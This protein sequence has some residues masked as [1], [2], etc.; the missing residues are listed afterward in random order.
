MATLACLDEETLDNVSTVKALRRY[1]HFEIVLR[2]DGSLDELGHGAMGTTYRAVDTVLQSQVALKVIGQNVADSP[3]VRSRFLREARAAA[4]LRHPNVASVFH[5]GEQQGECFYVME[6]VEGETLEE[7]VRRDGPLPVEIVLEIGFQV[8]CALT[9]AEAQGLVHRDLKPSNL[10]WVTDP[11][12]NKPG[13]PLLIKVIDFGLAKALTAEAE[14][15]GEN[16]T[17][18]VFT[19]TPAYAS[20][21]Q[22][23]R[24]DHPVDTRSDL[25]S[26]GVTL[27]YLLCGRTPFRGNTLEEIHR[28]QTRQPLPVNQLTA[29][30]IPGPVIASL[31]SLLAVDPRQRPQ[32][33]RE[34]IGAIKQ[35]QTRISPAHRRKL[36]RLPLTVSVL[37]AVSVL[38]AILLVHRQASTVA[39]GRPEAAMADR[40][41]AV[42][43][44]E[45]LSPN[46]SVAFFTSGVQDEITGELARIA[47]LKVVSPGE[48]STR[49][50]PPGKRDLTGIGQQLGVGH[51]I[52]GAVRRENDHAQITIKLTDIRNAGLNWSKTYEG[53]LS[54]IF[55]IQ[56]EVTRE[57]ANRLRVTLSPGEKAAIDDPPTTDPVA[58]DFYLRAM[59]GP[60]EF[61]GPAEIRQAMNDKL[62][63]LD[64]AVTRDPNFVAAYCAMANIHDQLYA[65]R[66]FGDEAD[67]AVDHHTLAEVALQKAQRLQRDASDVHLAQAMHFYLVGHDQEQARIELDLA[68][69]LLPNNAELEQV[70]GLIARDQGRWDD[71]VRNLQKSVAL[72]PR[73][74]ACVVSLA[75]VYRAMRRY[76]DADRASARLIALEPEEVSLYDRLFRAL[77]PLEE[78]ADLGPLREALGAVA[79]ANEE[80][81]NYQNFFRLTLALY[82]HDAEAL[83]R[84]LAGVAHP[85]ITHRGIVYPKTW[86]EGLA[87]RLRGDG[88]AAKT[89]FA[90][91]RIN[92]ERTTLADAADAKMLSLLAVVDAGLGRKEDA[93][94]EGQRAYAMM[95]VDK[96]ASDAPVVACNLAVVF[97]WSNEP[98]RA[99]DLLETWA[100]RSAGMQMVYQVTY[101]D[102][103]LNPQWDPIRNY[104]RFVALIK[105]LSA[106]RPR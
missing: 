61:A 79:S 63:L 93:V 97:A 4:R 98:D 46:H 40:S 74:A 3:V 94:R 28:Q 44:F 95:P 73:T 80:N 71:A 102:L 41:V 47:A 8:A 53:K 54:E 103:S 7:R 101:G 10:M 2:A 51:L 77:G 35:C 92:V 81:V 18:H 26:L 69:Q 34:V 20:P 88:V 45:N 90:A 62:A 32:S 23:A 50:Y 31:R 17:R 86:Y 100:G 105:R 60:W 96:F 33:V 42:L 48:D 84:T 82:A 91:A 12:V 83:S 11:H 19:G 55:A 1:S 75:E 87:A 72:S 38:T 64:Q 9:A 78:R 58:Y 21:E 106:A 29:R 56:H 76:E 16:D 15:L 66:L 68:R 30:R 99:T 65:I 39:T 89:A 22:F 13:D 27:W 70:A 36:G 6:L 67:K 5:Y 43:P 59:Q 24:G 49:V 52:E 37:L 25:Y 104:P 14:V 57:V 85:E